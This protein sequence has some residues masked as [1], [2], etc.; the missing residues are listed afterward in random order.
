MKTTLLVMA[1]VLAD[2]LCAPLAVSEG[3]IADDQ[4]VLTVAVKHFLAQPDSVFGSRGLVV[5]DAQTAVVTSDLDAATLSASYQSHHISVPKTA[6]NDFLARNRARQPSPALG[7]VGATVKL[8]S[9]PENVLSLSEKLKTHVQT[10]LSLRV[11]GYTPD[12]NTA[13]VMFEFTW[14]AMHSGQAY[15]LLKRSPTHTWVVSASDMDIYL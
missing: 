6:L 3:A 11:P 10:I 8:E 15:Y 12:R 13:L 2:C 9:D 5:V 7:N 1:A 4:A 14:S